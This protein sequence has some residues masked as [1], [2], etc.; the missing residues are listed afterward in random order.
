MHY[1]VAIIGGGPGGSTVGTLLKKYEPGIRVLILE[2]ERFPREHVGESQLPAIGAVLNEMGVW[3][4]VEAADFPI[5]IGATY[6]WGQSPDLW[7][8]EFVP[9]S[10]YRDAGR[11]GKF[12]GQ[13]QM[14]AFQ[15]DRGVYDKILLDHAREMGCEVREETGV[16]E[17]ER[18]GDRVGGLRL[19]GGER[20]TADTYIDA[21][22]NAA[23][24][25]RSMGV[26]ID[27]PTALK[28]IAMWDY[29]TN[30][31]WAVTVG[32]GATRV[33]VLSIG[34]G[35]IWFIPLS[36]TRTS[37]GF[38]CPADYYKERGISAEELYLEALS[39]E[40]RVREL[41]RNAAR[42]NNVRI[43]RDWSFVADRMAGENWYLVGESAGFADP[44]LAG[45][46][47]LTHTGGRECAYNI[48]A[49]RRGEH[50]A[51]WLK[52]TYDQRQ[53]RRIRQYIR[54]A[55]YWYAFNGQMTDLKSCT[56]EIAQ[57]CGLD[58]SP[59][60]AF[61]WLSL[62]GFGH[63]DFLFPGLGGLDLMAVKQIN[64]M[65]TAGS[66]A[67]WELNK[68][69]CFSLNLAGASRETMPVYA[70]GRVQVV[71]CHVRKGHWMP[72]AGL[73]GAVA[74]VLKRLSH[75]VD[76]GRELTR[77]SAAEG[78]RHGMTPNMFVAQS[79]ATLETMLLEGWV[80]GRV[81]KKKPMFRYAHMAPGD[82]MNIHP[83]R[84]AV[85]RR[86]AATSVS[87]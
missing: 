57:T 51:A 85:D 65:F 69:N 62:G 77:V 76:I 58:L 30:A 23:I 66:D 80:D 41:T 22:G 20:I 87:A 46:L 83:N 34:S 29:W 31:E 28:N 81:D 86:V 10:I 54:F 12:V 47:T 14:T 3:E 9:L 56:Q 50:E 59:D 2:R 61:R 11:P 35:W 84:D 52:R 49:E 40:P 16:S 38:I 25:R 19:A 71:P 82:E 32:R 53:R 73:Y 17:I 6:R 43:T 45:G 7:D 26:G 48:L 44:I 33:Q 36:Q 1:D 13:R 75:I 18:N 42:E 55:D 5:K 78:P 8:F 79:M 27:V 67:G 63:E 74:D 21:S 68:Y 60:Q 4:K 15:V 72:I 24:L 70:Q 37:I 39:R 64:K